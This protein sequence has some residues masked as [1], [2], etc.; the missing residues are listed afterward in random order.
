MKIKI[1]NRDVL[2]LLLA[3]A[4]LAFALIRTVMEKEKPFAASLVFTY[5]WEGREKILGALKEE[6][7][8]LHRGVRIIPDYRPYGEMEKIMTAGS[9]TGNVI[10]GDIIGGDV[11][12]L[13]PRWIEDPQK[14]AII[15]PEIYNLLEFLNPLFYNIDTLIEAGFNHPPK[16]LGEFLTQAREVTNTAEGK[17]AIAFAFGEDNSRGILQDLYSW[18]WSAGASSL[19][20]NNTL[21]GTLDFILALQRENLIHPGTFSMNE[22]KKREAFING[23]TAFMIGSAEDMNYLR[24]VMGE[25][26]FGYTAIP[27]PE[28][29]SGKPVFVSGSW[30]LAIRKNSAHRDEA[31]SFINFLAEHSPALAEGWAIPLNY[32]P[33]IPEPFY[34]KARELYATG[35]LIQD[36]SGLMPMDMDKV[37]RKELIDLFVGRIEAAEAGREIQEN[38]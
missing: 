21:N 15:E 14:H 27:A 18:I 3:L 6:Y 25:T 36:S 35:N 32:N 20:D 30:S 33:G 1:S 8:Q 24:Q 29:Y 22:N 13:D 9:S 37:F 12:A 26:T 34:S 5:S 2:L 38:P 10:E 23:K 7:E 11:I 16:T 19:A 28:N 31:L 4:V 17:Y